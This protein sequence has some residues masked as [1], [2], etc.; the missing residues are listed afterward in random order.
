[1]KKAF[2]A[3]GVL[4][5]AL[6]MLGAPSG[7]QTPADITATITAA[8]GSPAA[9]Q[10]VVV[11]A[12]FSSPQPSAAAQVR[13][14]TTGAVP[15][16]VSFTSGLSSCV[17]STT[18][19]TCQWLLPAPNVSPQTLVVS[20]P[21]GA[22]GSSITFNADVAPSVAGATFTQ[23]ATTSATVGQATTTTVVGGS[24]TVAPT[25]TPTTPTTTGTTTATT[26]APTTAAPTTAAP[27]TAPPGTLPATGSDSNLPIVIGLVAVAAGVLLVGGARVRRSLQ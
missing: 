8:P 23:K 20:I 3:F 2:M 16:L 13:I 25:T 24:T 18:A 6:V 1:M 26:A 15:T 21:A 7:A 27:T 12:T 5:V 17:S 11:T 4:A 9:G 19:V 10:N 14:S 22:A